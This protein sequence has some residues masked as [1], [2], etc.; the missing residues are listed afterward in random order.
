MSLKAE[1]AIILVSLVDLRN[2]LNIKFMG[3]VHAI[4]ERTPIGVVIRMKHLRQLSVE[5][6]YGNHKDNDTG[7]KLIMLEALQPHQNIER[8]RIEHYSGS[9]FPS[10]LMVENLGLLLPKLVHLHIE[11]CHKCQKLPPLWKLPS[12]QSLALRNLNELE[13]YDDKFTQ[14]S[15]T[16]TDECYY[17]SSL[18]QLELQGITEPNLFWFKAKS[19]YSSIVACCMVLDSSMNLEKDS[20]KEVKLKQARKLYSYYDGT[21]MKLR[22]ILAKNEDNFGRVFWVAIKIAR[23]QQKA[24]EAMKKMGKRSARD[25]KPINSPFSPRVNGTVIPFTTKART[26]R[27]S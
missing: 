18:K 15:K 3:R 26:S 20:A 14:L 4:G 17:F 25:V 12:L 2:I 23:M 11:D 13:G 1:A 9:R 8:L 21:T 24:L 16:L 10:R 7:T 5:A 27:L 19:F 22:G 6:A